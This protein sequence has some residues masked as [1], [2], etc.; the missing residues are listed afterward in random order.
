V[1]KTL[2]VLLRGHQRLLGAHRPSSIGLGQMAREKGKVSHK[3]HLIACGIMKKSSSGRGGRISIHG[4]L[5]GW[6][7]NQYALAH[8]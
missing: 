6:H 5:T 1:W 8:C 7:L 3:L 4:W 2:Q